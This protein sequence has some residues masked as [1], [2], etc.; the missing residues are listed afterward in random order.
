MPTN[1][2]ETEFEFEPHPGL[3]IGCNTEVRCE[4]DFDLH[5]ELREAGDVYVGLWEG[6]KQKWVHVGPDT[7]MGRQAAKAINDALEKPG[8]LDVAADAALADYDREDA[9][10]DWRYEQQR[11]DSI[12]EA[13]R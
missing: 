12:M 6:L 2:F 11:S 13:V 9:Y 7:A 1:T 5:G 3:G 4:L 10:G 8:A